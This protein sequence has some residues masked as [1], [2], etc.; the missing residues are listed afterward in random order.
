MA[1][2]IISISSCF[3]SL[4]VAQRITGFDSRS[5]SF[6]IISLLSSLYLSASS[7]SSIFIRIFVAKSLFVLRRRYSFNFLCF[8]S[9]CLFKASSCLFYS[10]ALS[11]SLTLFSSCTFASYS[12]TSSNSVSVCFFTGKSFFVFLLVN[13][14]TGC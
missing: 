9:S 8:S 13:N 10:A 14:L 2:L 6:N 1:S 11:T 7:F 5:S 3:G 12:M 4:G